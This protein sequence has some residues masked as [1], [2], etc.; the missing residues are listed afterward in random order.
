[1]L[2][3]QTVPSAA[4]SPRESNLT[5]EEWLGG[6]G[7][8]GDWLG[9]R[10]GLEDRGVE[11]FG[12]YTAE[13]WGNVAGGEN[14]GAVYTG[15]LEFGLTL[16]ME[17][18]VG[19]EGAT[20]HNSWLWLSGQDA[21]EKLVGDDIWGVSNI[22]GFNTLRMFE[23]WF[24]QAFY[25]D[26]F[27]I[28]LGQLSADQEFAISEYAGL[29]IDGTFGFPA[30]LTASLPGGGPQ[31]PLGTPGVRLELNPTDWFT[32]RTAAF[33]GDP[34]DEDVNRHGFRYRLDRAVG[35]LFMNEA[36]FR[37]NGFSDADLPGTFKSGAWFSSSEFSAPG[38]DDVSL[39]G[40][41]G[42]YFILDQALYRPDGKASDLSGSDGK[43]VMS[44]GK[45]S[46]KTFAPIEQSKVSSGLG[47]FT[48]FA[49]EPTDRNEISFYFD[50]GLVYQ[51]LIPARPADS[52]GVAMGYAKL[53][54]GA[55]SSLR[56][57]GA[58]DPGYSI[59]VE[60]TYQAVITDW[61]IVQ[62]DIQYII[63]PSATRDF[64]NSLVLGLRTTVTF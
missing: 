8:S 44:G 57:D 62:P 18:L 48:R 52:L 47:G 63:H 14:R 58:V 60:V 2:G 9:Y 33:Q 24:Q 45:G 25:D 29:F 54:P 31:Y 26:L 61:F 46:A 20:F 23:L 55:V 10:K 36:E 53:S 16:D 3:A 21:S 7:V 11:F 27:S 15:L 32:F 28:R 59:M 39:W 43:A 19:W 12:S 35:Y 37:W 50:A 4:V 1:M 22:A 13:V 56:D 49:F 30:A 6:D 5:F 41:T 51:G 64:A 40:N 38:N 34:F 42:F 17:K